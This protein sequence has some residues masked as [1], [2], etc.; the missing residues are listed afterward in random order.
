MLQEGK[1]KGAHPT[2]I[3]KE[4]PAF[5]ISEGGDSCMRGPADREVGRTGLGLKLSLTIKQRADHLADKQETG[6][7]DI[8][9][10]LVGMAASLT[11]NLLV[12]RSLL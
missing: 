3:L 11:T 2:L 8:S 1:C 5:G 4:I 12:V 6:S 10:Q 7:E 9:R